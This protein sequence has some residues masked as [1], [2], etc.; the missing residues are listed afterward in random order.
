[1]IYY[2]LCARIT[3]CYYSSRR[4]HSSFCSRR[5]RVPRGAPG[6]SP[7]CHYVASLAHLR[8]AQWTGCVAEAVALEP[9]AVAALEWVAPPDHLLG[10]HSVLLPPSPPLLL[11]FQEPSRLSALRGALAET[12]QSAPALAVETRRGRHRA[13]CRVASFE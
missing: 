10:D 13:N 7:D 4:S 2:V 1:M 9:A 5:F 6:P 8:A 12:P 11:L 3:A